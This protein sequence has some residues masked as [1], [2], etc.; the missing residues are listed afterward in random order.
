MFANKLVNLSNFVYQVED[1]NM[2]NEV[3][4]KIDQSIFGVELSIY[5][6]GVSKFLV[7]PP[8]IRLNKKRY[9]RDLQ[10]FSDGFDWFEGYMSKPYFLPHSQAENGKFID[11]LISLKDIF[12][13]SEEIYVQILFRKDN[14][15]KENVADLYDSYLNGNGNPSNLSIWRGLQNKAIGKVSPTKLDYSEDVE[16]KILSQGFQFELRVAMNVEAKEDAEDYINECL[17]QYDFHNAMRIEEVKPRFILDDFVER[18]ICNHKQIISKE[19][20]MSFVINQSSESVEET[21][22]TEVKTND[23]VEL[24]PNPES[25]EVEIDPELEKNL[26][27]AL[28]RVK[29]TSQARLYNSEITAGSRLTI[30]QCDIPNDKNFTHVE[31][32][33]KDIQAAMGVS[34]LSI[35]QGEKAGTVKFSIPN[36]DPML[37]SL[38][39]ILEGEEFQ[40]FAKDNPLAFPLGLS[41]MNEPLYLSLTDL[42]HLGVFGT[43]GSGKSVFMN[44]LISSLLMNHTPN[45]LNMIMIDPKMVELEGYKDFPHVSDVI[46]DM[47]KANKVLESL[48]VKMD[49]R[50]EELSKLGVKNIQGYNKKSNNK[51][52]YI[53]MVIDEFADMVMVDP[54]VEDFI[55][56]LG[57]KARA[58]GIHIVIATQRPDAETVTGKIKANIQNRISF[59]LGNNTDYK[60]VFSTGIPYKLLGKGDGV[61]KIEGY[62]KDFQRFQSAIIDPDDDKVEKFLKQLKKYYKGYEKNTI[63]VEEEVKPIDELKKIIATT[64]ET[65]ASKLQKEMGI[66]DASI[67]E[68]MSD[69]VEEE[70][71]LKHKSRAKG[72]ELIAPKE[73]LDKYKEEE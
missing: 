27:K 20:L 60:T 44:S 48:T 16:N 37:I 2:L 53:V 36:E 64:G 4:E 10:P 1:L 13:D 47:E 52:P 39:S 70:W 71:L 26:A 9:E 63:E 29:I 17:R 69:L 72:Y 59:N 45:E 66:R 58:A 35:E 51:M 73:E 68:L 18:K 14:S 62:S 42:V 57:Q 28:N 67:K 56:R 50:Y 6:D 5:K 24:L 32:K 49:E 7:T 3:V 15:W 40:K 33:R 61:A 22:Q 19:E 11:D 34:S 55:I 31:K 12:G 25:T 38:R 8:H 54:N 65:R 21:E 30:L 46:T 23:I 41:D 43:T